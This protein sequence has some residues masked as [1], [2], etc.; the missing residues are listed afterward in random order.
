MAIGLSPRCSSST[1]LSTHP[2]VSKPV[3]RTSYRLYCSIPSKTA[4]NPS[5]LKR[6][7]ASLSSP[8]EPKPAA[9]TEQNE[10]PDPSK[11]SGSSVL[12]LVPL[13][14]EGFMLNELGLEI[15][16]I[17]LPAALALAADP[18]A[19][20]V[21]TAFVGHIGSVELAAVGVSASIFNLVSKLFNVPLLNITTSFV[22]EEQALLVKDSDDSS[23]PSNGLV[24][25]HQT[26]KFLPSVSTSL[27]LAACLG[28]AETVALSAGSGFL[29]N[30][31]GVGN[32]L[33]A[34]LDPIL[35]FLF[36]LGIGGA[37]IAT[38]ISEYLIALILLWKMN[39]EVLLISPNVD[40]GIVV[41]YLKS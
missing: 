2:S 16:S 18:V 11:S 13:L 37:A 32:L 25:E 31:M 29:M 21:D 23:Q 41:R 20:L 28:I 40:G 17:A 24:I 35:I 22:A 38:V 14:R 8:P 4:P 19:S 12:D 9:S 33:N 26:K 34:V 27:G 39:D 30:L 15:L 36:S 5:P 1:Y 3:Q 7:T 6:A 10:R